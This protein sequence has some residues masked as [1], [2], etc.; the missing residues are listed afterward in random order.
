M[1]DDRERCY[2][3]ALRILSYRFNSEGELRRKLAA[4][5]FERETIDAAIDKLRRENWIDDD[6]FAAAFVR[7]RLRKGIGRLRIK[8]ELTAAGVAAETASAALV[9]QGGDVSH[10]QESLSALC[11]KKIAIIARRHG[12]DYVRSDQGRKK[13]AAYLLNQGYEMAAVLD[14]IRQALRKLSS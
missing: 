3:A 12:T 5:D 1:P 9:E 7:T 10:E 14:A 11:A 13:V 2:A 6:R 8:R 4:K